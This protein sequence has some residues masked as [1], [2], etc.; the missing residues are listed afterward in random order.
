MPDEL[1]IPV[2]LAKEGYGTPQQIADMRV[3]LVM[4]AVRYSKFLSD[5]QET[6]TQLNKPEP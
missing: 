3:D 2:R 6:T 1:L 5:L 4:A